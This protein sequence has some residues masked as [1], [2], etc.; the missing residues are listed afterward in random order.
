MPVL[1]MIVGFLYS[2]CF[3]TLAVFKE[4]IVLGGN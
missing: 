4:Q 1:A 2:G 3:L